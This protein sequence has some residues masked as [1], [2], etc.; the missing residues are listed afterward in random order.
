[1]ALSGSF[2]IKTVPITI[3]EIDIELHINIVPTRLT[4]A[5]QQVLNDLE[6][7]GTRITLE[8]IFGDRLYRINID[9]WQET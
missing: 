2:K 7:S 4:F 5:S 6:L 1:M 8:Y 3:E 9:L